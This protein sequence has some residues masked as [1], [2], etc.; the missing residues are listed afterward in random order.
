MP[1]LTGSALN[2]LKAALDGALLPPGTGDYERAQLGFNRIVRGRPAA[3]VR[4]ADAADVAA[5]VRFAADHGLPLAVQATGHGVSVPADGALLIDTRDMDEVRIDPGTRTARIGA[6]AS[7]S[8]VVQAAA[9]HGL[10]PLNG[11][12]PSV[13]AVGYTLGGGLGPL[14]RSY[15]YSADHVRCLDVV[16]ADGTLHRVTA[17]SHANLFWGLR[18]GKGNFGVVTAME[19]AL[20]PVPSLYGG[21]LFL[22]ADRP[23]R[24]LRAWRDWTRA[25][26]DAMQSSLALGPFPPDDALP[27]QVR[28]R[29]LAHIRVAFNGPAQEGEALVRP[30]RQHGEPVADTLTDR[31]YAQ[32]AAIH[33]DPTEPGVYYERSTRLRTLDDTTIDTL[34]ALAEE[35]AV[36]WRPNIEL[37]HLGGALARRPR[38]PNAVPYREA[39]YTLFSGARTATD[40]EAAVAADYQDRL[41]GAMGPWRIG[42]PFLSFISA[43]EPTDMHLRSAYDPDTYQEL[44]QLKDVWDPGNIFRVNHNIPPTTL[45]PTGQGQG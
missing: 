3:V 41:I 42:G 23:D 7:W 34:A 38:H 20:F 26:P 37:R 11:A 4:A 31:P 19:V 18:G 44:V 28:G 39:A 9:A 45:P 12:A 35:G 16:T 21:G 17:D 5:C 32:V 43:R 8:Q 40:D 14:G 30:L 24:L 13:G 36:A 6:G 10:A 1:T 33:L 2:T 22:P 27:P 29:F 25:I 15:G